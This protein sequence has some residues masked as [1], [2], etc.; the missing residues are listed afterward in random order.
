MNYVILI[1]HKNFFPSLQV[2]NAITKKSQN[3]ENSCKSLPPTIQ[4]IQTYILVG[5]NVGRLVH[6]HLSYIPDLKKIRRTK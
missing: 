5:G 4:N 3:L 1:L 6:I 2:S